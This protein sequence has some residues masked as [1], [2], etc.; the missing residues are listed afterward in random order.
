MIPN[1]YD[2]INGKY[3]EV[4]LFGGKQK[5]LFFDGRILKNGTPNGAYIYDI[6]HDDDDWGKPI[7]IC[8]SVIVNYFG[9]IITYKPIKLQE[10]D[11]QR[12]DI[13]GLND[14]SFTDRYFEP[15]AVKEWIRDMHGTD[16]HSEEVS[17]FCNTFIRKACDCG[18]EWD[19]LRSLFMAG[20]C[21]YFA[22]MMRSAFNR[23]EVYIAAP[24]GHV[25]WRDIDDR[26][27]DIEGEYISDYDA[28]IPVTDPFCSIKDFK[29]LGE[30]DHLGASKEQIEFLI[31]KYA[32]SFPN[33]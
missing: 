7:E 4:E 1:S 32:H 12:L 19:S 14:F 30:K 10:L 20:Y 8:R 22:E 26:Y 13:D 29:H 5:A 33:A 28:M 3:A 23:G 2:K 15:S 18:I 17:T 24:Y 16:N 25:V 21:Y 6:R 27:Y 11:S 31:N 9:T